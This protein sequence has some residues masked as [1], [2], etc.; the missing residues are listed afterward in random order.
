[1]YQLYVGIDIAAKTAHVHWQEAEQGE[2]GHQEVQQCQR[3]YARLAQRLQGIAD[4]GA[5]LVVMEATSNYWL[6]IALYLY[7][8][9]F[10]VSVIN[11]IRG[12]HFAKLHLR[13]AKTDAID[14]ALLCQFG[15][16]IHPDLWT[17]PPTI[18]HRLQ[19]RLGL[20]EDL[21]KTKTQY[22]NRLHAMRYQ[23]YAEASL[24]VRLERQIALLQQEIEQLAAEIEALLNSD[25]EWREAALRLQTIPGIG[26]ITTAWLLTATHCFARCDTPQQAAAYAGLAPHARDS[27]SSL[28]G[29]RQTGGGHA[30]LRA[31]LYLAAGSALQHNPCLKPFY[32]RLV[33]R[34]KIKQV[35]R[36]AVARKLVHMAWAVVVKHRDFDPH[37][38]QHPLAA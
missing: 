6:E 1:M 32:Q 10:R 12:R 27:G 17:P 4:P 15:Q 22:R 33:Q 2:S 24:I 7:E 11:P 13:R 3:D 36:V 35:A 34:G 20:R 29:K 37:Y 30:Q 21:L 5:S 9:G 8:A 26:L 25:H 18:Y 28:H 14:A 16:T 19:Q 38:A 31:S 23:P